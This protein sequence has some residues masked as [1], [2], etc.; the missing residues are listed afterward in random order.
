MLYP[1]H[2]RYGI[3]WG[4][5]TIPIGVAIGLIP[6]ISSELR[7]GDLFIM[8]MTVIMGLIGALFGSR[9]PDIDSPGSIPARRH[10]II[11]KLFK[12]FGVKHRGKFSHDFASIGA[13]FGI[14]YLLVSR[15]GENFI[16]F[17]SQSDSK[18]VY[19]ISTWII[20]IIMYLIGQEIV[21]ELQDLA[22]LLKN[23]KMWAF[24]EKN[25]FFISSINVLWLLV[26]LWSTG[27]FKVSMNLDTA[28]WSATVTVVLLKVF[29]VFTLAG[30][31][32][33]LF[34]DMTTKSGVS[35]FGKKLA[36]AQVILKLKKIPVVGQ[37]LVPTEFKTG[38]KWEDFNRM[39]VTILII[40]ASALAT[41]FLFGFN[42][43]EIKEIFFN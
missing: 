23:K 39:I 12:R 38:S 13:F 5:L 10:P 8:T 17:V 4:V 9:F 33:H 7:T 32:S 20:I 18:I 43:G 42:L 27:N 25:S 2:K 22:N 6:V 14:I 21:S 40:P 11:Q 37:V 41:L 36:P 28:L 26:L 1:T 29:V 19:G 31:Y 16:I 15:V 24:L 35:I 3:L 34:A 30:A